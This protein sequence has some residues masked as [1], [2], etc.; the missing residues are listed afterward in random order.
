MKK[1]FTSLILFC[2]S[3]ASFAAEMPTNAEAQK[4]LDF[5]YNGQGMG[6]VLM[7]SKIC[8]EVIKEGDNKNECTD[9]MTDQPINKGESVNVWMAYLVPKGD[10]GIKII[11]Q[12][13]QGGITRMVKNLT[14]SGSIRFRTWRKVSF[15]KTGNWTVKVF[16]DRGTEVDL[17]K[18]MTLT[19]V[20]R[21]ESTAE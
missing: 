4:V 19:V 9:D 21:T 5:Y 3:T 10:E 8:S 18:E 20:A 17:L 12:F 14:L 11:M 1:I 16:H 13:E 15:N 6:V 2:L 7:E